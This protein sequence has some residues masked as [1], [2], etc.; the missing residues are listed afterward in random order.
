MRQRVAAAIFSTSPNMRSDWLIH[1]SGQVRDAR[2]R[3][4]RPFSPVADS[5]GRTQRPESP[6]TPSLRLDLR[7]TRNL[8]WLWV[9]RIVSIPFLLFGGQMIVLQVWP[10][11]RSQGVIDALGALAFGVVFTWSGWSLWT[12]FEGSPR[13]IGAVLLA[14]RRCVQCAYDLA[15][16]KPD[17]DGC[18]TCPECGSAWRLPT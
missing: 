5:Y 16:C 6:L 2:G 1:L 18:T 12:Q 15:G 17:S 4:V 14:H 10:I 8:F 7:R 9:A 11:L 3:A 13:K